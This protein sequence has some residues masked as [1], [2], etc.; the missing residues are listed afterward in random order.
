MTL[1]RPLSFEKSEWILREKGSWEAYSCS[2]RIAAY[3]FELVFYF[4]PAF[5]DFLLSDFVEGGDGRY[6]AERIIPTWVE[7][8]MKVQSARDDRRARAL[9]GRFR[10]L[11]QILEMSLVGIFCA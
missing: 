10:S 1:E 9:V 5:P 11:G 4:S 8:T 7:F 2:P 6:A 3:Y